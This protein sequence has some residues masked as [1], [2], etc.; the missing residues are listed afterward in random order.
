MYMFVDAAV[1]RVAALPCG[2]DV[3]PW[4]DPCGCGTTSEQ[5]A[6][7]RCSLQQV[8]ASEAREDHSWERVM[9]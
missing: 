1:V 6:Q 8:Q 4:P 2:V 3:P 9:M 7:W 5:V